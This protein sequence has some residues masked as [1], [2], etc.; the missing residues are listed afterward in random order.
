MSL[1]SWSYVGKVT[2]FPLALPM[3]EIDRGPDGEG[4]DEPPWVTVTGILIGSPDCLVRIQID[5]I[6]EA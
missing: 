4:E 3:T 6:D 2:H 1:D 5:V